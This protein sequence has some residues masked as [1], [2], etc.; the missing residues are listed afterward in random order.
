MS[1]KLVQKAYL[2]ILF[3]LFFINSSCKEKD[4]ITYSNYELKLINKIDNPSFG[5]INS[6]ARYGK[7]FFLTDIADAQVFCFDSNYDFKYRFGDKGKGPGELLQPGSLFVLNDTIYVYESSKQSLQLY[8][9][10]GEY[11]ESFKLPLGFNSAERFFL[12]SSLVLYG[13][14][15]SGPKPI[16]IKNLK[17]GDIIK[18]GNNYNNV[19]ANALAGF[20]F[21]DMDK[22]HLIVVAMFRPLLYK[23]NKE[24]FMIDSLDLASFKL[25]E[26]HNYAIELLTSNQSSHSSFTFF[27][28]KDAA[29]F[30]SRLFVLAYFL[31][32]NEPVYD[33]T[34]KLIEFSFDNGFKIEAVYE[35]QDVENTGGYSSFCL[36][37]VDDTLEFILVNSTLREIHVFKK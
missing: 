31:K 2:I 19:Q 4:N 10:K 21:L 37:E 13:S 27:Y 33:G 11:L 20:H 17:T 29:V 16:I 14:I 35:F 22:N 30:N 3:I 36:K 28:F 32:P 5:R 12:D 23:M 7:V 24:G 25:F 18:T 9:L 34:S 15:K 26:D 8:D 6:V 1:F